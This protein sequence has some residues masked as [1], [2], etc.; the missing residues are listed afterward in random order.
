[1]QQEFSPREQVIRSLQLWWVLAAC[2]FIGGMVGYLIQRVE[3]PIYQAKA[4]INTFIDFQDIDDAQLSEYDEDMTINTVKVVMLS[5]DVIDTVI[6]LAKTEGISIDPAIFM[7]QH[8]IYRTHADYELFYRD[9]DPETAMRVVNLWAEAGVQRFKELQRGGNM[10][11]YVSIA[12]TSPADLPLEPT[13]AQANT[14]VFS[15][16]L[17]GFIFGI[18]LTSFIPR[19]KINRV[20]KSAGVRE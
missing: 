5:S 10:P 12:L 15:G 2:I 9:P 1:M 17:L 6:N 16:A 11:L 4:I 7:E 8:N 18:A 14:Y 20:G 3:P 19:R 13:Y